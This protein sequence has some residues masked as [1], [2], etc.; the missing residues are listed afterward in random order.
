[1]AGASL[2]AGKTENLLLKHLDLL[3]LV[4]AGLEAL[5]HL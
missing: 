5:D 2:S 3:F 1:M 4:V